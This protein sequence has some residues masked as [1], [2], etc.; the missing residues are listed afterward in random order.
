MEVPLL[1][2][3]IALVAFAA[4]CGLINL[5]SRVGALEDRARHQD[6]AAGQGP[7]ARRAR[8]EE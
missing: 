5:N 6:I 1:L 7:L 8:G 3:L 2:G 4:G